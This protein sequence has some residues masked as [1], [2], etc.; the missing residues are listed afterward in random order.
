MHPSQLPRRAAGILALVTSIALVIASA[1]ASGDVRDSSAG[2]PSAAAADE[3]R[4]STRVPVRWFV[5][6]G[7]SA[8]PIDVA[9]AKPI[10]WVPGADALARSLQ[11]VPPVQ[12]PVVTIP[13]RA[14]SSTRAEDDMSRPSAT[15]QSHIPFTRAEVLDPTVYP[16]VVHGKLFVEWGGAVGLC[17]GTVVTSNNSS[18]VVTAAHCLMNPNNGSTPD[19]LLFAPGYRLGN[20]PFGLWESIGFGVTAEWGRSVSDGAADPRYDVGAIVLRP[21]DDGQTIGDLLGTRGISFNQDAFQLFDAFGYPSAGPF[22]GERLWLCDSETSELLTLYPAPRP[23]AI[24]CDMTPGSSGGGWVVGD[25]FVN[26]LNSFRLLG[27]DDVMYG[28]QFGSSALDLYEFASDYDGESVP[29]ITHEMSVSIKASGH[30]VLAGRLTANDGYGP[31]TRRAFIEVFKKKSSSKK[32][33]GG[34]VVKT[35]LTDRRGRFRVKVPDKP[36]YYYI[37]SPRSFPDDDNLCSKAKSKVKRH[38][39]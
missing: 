25:A 38:R 12:A 8:A 24:G 7:N 33:T 34:R 27:H 4:S 20:A 31:C 36:G 28:P 23:H 16:Y 18:V 13:P 11:P 29:P 5:P 35:G 6:D 37:K 15:F 32:P 17:S 14:P 26:S 9:R 21:N 22:D 39:H 10:S 2:G 30:L 1:P 3:G 19:R